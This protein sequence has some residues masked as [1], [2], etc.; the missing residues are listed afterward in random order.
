AD[1][2]HGDPQ[3]RVS[4]G[5][6]AKQHGAAKWLVAALLLLTVLGAVVVVVHDRF[7]REV[8]GDSVPEDDMGAQTE[9]MAVQSLEP[10]VPQALVQRPVK[11]PGLKSWTIESVKPRGTW[12]MD[13]QAFSPDGHLLAAGAGSGAIYLW[14]VDSGRLLHILLGHQRSG[15]G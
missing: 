4:A 15:A 6:H 7:G 5:E 9:T 13:S 12:Y 3:P 8:P 11:L 14:D 1:L 10:I 2:A